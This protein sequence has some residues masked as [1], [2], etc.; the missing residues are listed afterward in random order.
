MEAANWRHLKKSVIL[1]KRSTIR[2][3]AADRVTHI[4]ELLEQII[5]SLELR[6]LLLAR[7]VCRLWRDIIQSSNLFN[8]IKAEPYVAVHLRLPAPCSMSHP[9]LTLEAI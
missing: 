1:F 7:R 2:S 5:L 6:D 9:D 8:D 4:A 3:G